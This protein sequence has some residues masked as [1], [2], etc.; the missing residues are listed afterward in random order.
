MLTRGA[1]GMA[2]IEMADRVERAVRRHAGHRYRLRHDP[3][4]LVLY[5]DPVELPAHGWK[6][7]VSARVATFPALV[8]RLVP[9]LL[10][11]GC[12]FKLARSTR[13]LT[14][15][16]DGH[17]S[18][19]TVGKAFTVYPAADRVREV[20]LGLAALLHGEQGPRVPSDRAVDPTAPVYY[21]YGPFAWSW[22]ADANGRP[23]T[24]VHGPDGALATP[25]YRQP[26]WPT[27]PFTGGTAG[28]AVLAGRYRVVDGLLGSGRGTVYRAVDERDGAAVVVKQARARVDE[29]DVRLRL[30]NERRVLVALDG[31]PGVPRF[32]DHFRYGPDEFLVV[33][34]A[35][36]GNLADDVARAGR[37]PDRAG[38]GRTLARLGGRLARILAEL[39]D[40]GVVV[41]DLTPRT[42]AV[43]GDRVTLVDFGLA[44]FDGVELPGGTPG[45][46][47]ARQRRGDPPRDTDDLYA[48]G[49]V[50]LFACFGTRPVSLGT[51]RDAPRRQAL[52]TIRQYVGDAPTGVLAAVV[53]L[54][55]DDAGRARAAA[56]ALATG[57]PVRS[58]A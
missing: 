56:R 12:A 40:R 55:G 15:L 53:D 52:A 20:G 6:L 36:A 19:G 8:D 33:G 43:D 24:L 25:R 14:R 17:R 4:W 44:A 45:Y 39:H 26:P 2:D 23:V 34:D 16:N 37:Y 35:G 21:R 30:R 13:V 58:S 38:D 32:V 46:A 50:L 11:W 48:L 49:M 9:V 3:T 47:P 41:H 1:Y 10:D 5:P 28:D 7:H 18:P 29:H 54:L 51:D 22:G 57:A 27:D 42:V 31:V